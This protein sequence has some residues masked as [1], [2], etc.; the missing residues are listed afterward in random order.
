MAGTSKSIS[1]KAASRVELDLG[2]GI[3]KA[4]RGLMIS[5][6]KDDGGFVTVYRGSRAEFIEA[7]IP[8][9]VIDQPTARTPYEFRT[10]GRD[11]ELART[12]ESLEL[13]LHWPDHSPW[14]YDAGHPALDEISRM[15]RISAGMWLRGRTSEV[16]YRRTM[17]QTDFLLN[18][19]QSDY[20]QPR[21]RKYRLDGEEVMR[22]E[23][24]ISHL[25]AEI[26]RADVWLVEVPP[27]VKSRPRRKPSPAAR[28]KLAEAA[29]NDTQVQALIAS[30]VDKAAKRKPR[31]G[32][33][34]A[35]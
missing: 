24:I 22:L 16:D 30:A 12:A 4:L 15:I 3:E 14:Y 26:A 33:P 27:V 20:R 34:D 1:R 19:E 5:Q 21:T 9:A 25:C 18:S 11:A 8:A 31:R 28:A 6:R 29:K 13:T 17:V 10:D 23:N 7:G 32:S 35:A 2:I